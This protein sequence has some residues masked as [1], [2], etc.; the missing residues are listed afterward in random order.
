MYCSDNVIMLM[1][2]ALEDKNAIISRMKLE[3]KRLK[4]ELHEANHKRMLAEAEC[5]G[6]RR[7]L[8]AIHDESALL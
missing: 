1:G 2:E 3:V 5:I 7:K 6:L 4:R 8:E